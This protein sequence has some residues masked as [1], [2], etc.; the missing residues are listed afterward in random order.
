M[1]I[2]YDDQ[3]TIIPWK[4]DVEFCLR[5]ITEVEVLEVAWQRVVSQIKFDETL[6]DLPF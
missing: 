4:E 1:M 5:E 3:F 2:I 6:G